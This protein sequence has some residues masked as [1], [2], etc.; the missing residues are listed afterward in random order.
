MLD[1]THA[2]TQNITRQ[3][4]QI[5]WQAEKEGR[6]EKVSERKEISAGQAALARKKIR[7]PQAGGPSTPT[8]RKRRRNHS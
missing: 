8:R 6:A 4:V 1:S 5:I 3:K 7:S 2:E